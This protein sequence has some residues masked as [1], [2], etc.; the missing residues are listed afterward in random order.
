MLTFQIFLHINDLC[1]LEY[2]KNKL[3]CGHIS[4]SGFNCHYFVNDKN[5]LIKVII[6]IFNSV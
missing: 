5:L 6:P 2:I 4:I 3:N 1:V